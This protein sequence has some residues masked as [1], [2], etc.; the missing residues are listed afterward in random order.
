MTVDFRHP[1]FVDAL[2]KSNGEADLL[3]T[4][5]PLIFGLD[6][7]WSMSNIDLVVISPPSAAVLETGSKHHTR[8]H[9]ALGLGGNWREGTSLDQVSHDRGFLGVELSAR[10]MRGS[11]LGPRPRAF[12]HREPESI[13]A[14]DSDRPRMAEG[15]ALLIL[16]L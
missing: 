13:T 15:V 16:K 12:D 11:D 8:I 14:W 6:Q 2:G 5:R 10:G 7:P 9:E 4:F 1:D 3:P